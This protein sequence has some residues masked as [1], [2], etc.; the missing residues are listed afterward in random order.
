MVGTALSLATVQAQEPD[1]TA[2]PSYGSHH[3]SAGFTP[4]PWV[5]SLQ[6]G[7]STPVS[8]KLGP[9]C[10]GYIMASAPDIDL[11]YTAGSMPLYITVTSSAD[12]TLVVNAPDGRWYCNDDFS[13]LDPVVMFQNPPSGMYNVWV[14]VHGSD[15][16]QPATLKITELNP[17]N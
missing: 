17:A 9:N 8:A 7:G 5:Q 16:M 1:W 4:D 10:T 12:T 14:G 13:G 15:Q 6:A 11:H 3:L 2:E